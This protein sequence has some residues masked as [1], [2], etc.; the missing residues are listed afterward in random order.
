MVLYVREMTA[1]EE[2]ELRDWAVSDDSELKTSGA[3]DIA[4]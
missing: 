2:T 3:V 4:L 1:E